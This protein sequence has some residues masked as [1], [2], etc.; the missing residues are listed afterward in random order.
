MRLELEKSAFLRLRDLPPSR[1]TA[2]LGRLKEI[3]AAPFA[4]HANVARLSGPK[5]MFRLRIGD[6][7]VL[8]WIDRD[9]QTMI[10]TDIDVRG[11]IYR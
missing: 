11:S 2:L 5:D 10:V 3:A 6:W 4:V 9:S 8:Y 1:R 7:R